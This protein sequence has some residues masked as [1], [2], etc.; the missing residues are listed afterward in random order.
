MTAHGRGS[1]R[2][3]VKRLKA[4][5]RVGWR[6][7]ETKRNWLLVSPPS[8]STFSVPLTYDSR[9][10]RSMV[11]A[12]KT[13]ERHGLLEAEEKLNQINE[14]RRLFS[15]KKTQVDSD[16][17]SDDSD[18]DDSD[19]RTEE[20]VKK[21]I[22]RDKG[23]LGYVDGVAIAEIAPAKIV[24]P[25][26]NGAV[27]MAHGQELLLA[28]GNVVYRCVKPGTI[29]EPGLDAPCHRTFASAASLRAHLSAH[30]RKAAPTGKTATSDAPVSDV[31][32]RPATPA[33][34][35]QRSSDNFDFADLART[36][37]KTST[38]VQ[39][40]I[41]A[42]QQAVSNMRDISKAVEK[43]PHVDEATVAKAKKWDEMRKLM[44]N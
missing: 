43:L 22:A 33:R 12:V 16:S 32:K 37:D 1:D 13:A 25:I 27:P 19:E 42:L 30:S 18:N 2:D 35:R 11:S 41:V 6:M 24:T 34:S 17:D 26:T 38:Q 29:H 9:N 31:S 20:V 3:L 36:L 7:R 23:D 39:H 5:E 40:I 14:A 28:D 44:G 4:L 10:S 21:T 8:G 15:L